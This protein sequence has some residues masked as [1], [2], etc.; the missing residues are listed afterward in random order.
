MIHLAIVKKCIWPVICEKIYFD[1]YNQ[2]RFHSAIAYIT[3][4]LMMTIK[5]SN[6]K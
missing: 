6:Y 3:P 1:S 5:A 2:L 4:V